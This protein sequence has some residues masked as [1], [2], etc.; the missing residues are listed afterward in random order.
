MFGDY[1]PGDIFYL[2]VYD[3][4]S[5]DVKLLIKGSRKSY[6]EIVDVLPCYSCQVPNPPGEK[7]WIEQELVFEYGPKRYSL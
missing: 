5:G 1:K 4:F 7:M 6:I 3:C 2:A